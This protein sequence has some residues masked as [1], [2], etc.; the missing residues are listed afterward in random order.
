VIIGGI[1]LLLAFFF[2]PHI[3]PI[4]KL[5]PLS[6]LGILLVFAGMYLGLTIL[7]MFARKDMF[8]VLLILGITLT[9][10]LAWAVLVGIILSQMLKSDKFSI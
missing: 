10:N 6:V 5:L 7:D 4:I 8:V 3:L 9:A 2:G 1:F